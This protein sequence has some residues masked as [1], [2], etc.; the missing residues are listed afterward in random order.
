MSRSLI[1]HCETTGRTDGQFILGDPHCAEQIA[2][3][4]L[5]VRSV[6]Y[7][8]R[9][10]GYPT[11]RFEWRNRGGG[12]D[13][14]TSQLIL[15]IAALNQWF[16]PFQIGLSAQ[17]KLQIAGAPVTDGAHITA[18]VLDKFDRIWIEFEVKL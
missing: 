12:A 9:S 2:P 18:E 13:P 14:A 15:L 1:S 4:N 7:H 5:S 3:P 10:A 11:D 17:T 6:I 16:G 8:S